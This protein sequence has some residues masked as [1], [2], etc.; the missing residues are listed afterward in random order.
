MTTSAALLA[1]K[2]CLLPMPLRKQLRLIELLEA[3]ST[4][5]AEQEYE[6]AE[7]AQ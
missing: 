6:L 2:A 3:N 4:L 1:I 5:S 7:L